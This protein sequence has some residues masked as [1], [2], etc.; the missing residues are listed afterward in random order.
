MQAAALLLLVLRAITSIEAAEDDVNPDDNEEDFAALCAL[1]ALANLQTTVP[2]I[3]TSGLGAY[4]N[5]QQLKLTLSS[6]EWKNLFNKA[7]DTNA[8]PKQPPEEFQTDPTWQKQWP[9][10]AAA[11]EALD[12]DGKEAAVLAEAGL[13]NAPDELRT[14]ARQALIPISAQAEPLRERLSEV[15]RQNKDTTTATVAKALNKAGYGQDKATGAEYD[16]ADAFNG[17]VGGNTQ[18][19]CKA[20]GDR[21]KATTV[22]ATIVCLCHK[23]TGGRD[24]ANACGRLIIHQSDAGANIASAA[25]DFGDIMATCIAQPPKPL[26]ARYLDNA[27]ANIVSK[28]RFKTPN[29]YLGKFKSTGCTGSNNEGLCVEYTA[30]TA[31]TLQ[32]FYDILWVKE[33]SNVAESLKRAEKEVA[34]STL[35]STW[36]KASENEGN[37][38]AQKLIQ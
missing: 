36:L 4:D 30:L 3:D 13:E 1:A 32:K 7:S 23:K 25:P 24:G 27:V 33:V 9:I 20:G 12:G 5:L 22:A 14:M 38:V 11:A 28:L 8:P 10:W 2:S 6:K 15:Q 26:T 31:A 17:G 18:T 16:S 19:A 29:A 35:L 34:E 37:S 21:A